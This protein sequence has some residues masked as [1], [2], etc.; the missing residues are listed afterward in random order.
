MHELSIAIGIVEIAEK[1]TRKVNKKKV[2]SIELEIGTLSGIE[3]NA[4]EY[5]WEI[6]VSGTVLEHSQKKITSIDAKATCLD[7]NTKFIITNIYD[8]CPLCESY[9]KEIIKGKELIVKSIEVS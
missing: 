1:E 4:L 3:I 6:A 8:L 2:D 5:A 7:C 9:K